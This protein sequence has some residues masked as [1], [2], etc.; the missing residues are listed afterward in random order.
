MAVVTLDEPGGATVQYH[1]G[2]WRTHEPAYLGDRTS[3][4]W[5][6]LSTAAGWLSILIDILWLFVP[7]L[8]ALYAGLRLGSFLQIPGDNYP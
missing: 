8:V 1:P 7:F 3:V 4:G 6:P 2:S 5:H